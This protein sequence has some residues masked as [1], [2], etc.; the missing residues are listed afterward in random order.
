MDVSSGYVKIATENHHFRLVNPTISMAIFHSYV[1]IPEGTLWCHQTW[2]AGEWKIE[3]G[4][5]PMTPPI[6]KG[7][8]TAMFV[9]G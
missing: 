2:R 5:F 4:D 8:S 3:I 6:H 7:F 1:K 9:R